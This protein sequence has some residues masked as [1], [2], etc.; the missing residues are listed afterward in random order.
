MAKQR[1]TVTLDDSLCDKVEDL[2]KPYQ[3]QGMPMTFSS[4]LNWLG[5]R[6]TGLVGDTQEINHEEANND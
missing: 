5:L 3:E 2:V 1:R 6:Q 4:M